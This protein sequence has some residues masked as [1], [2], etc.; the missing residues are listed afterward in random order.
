MG[1]GDDAD[2]AF[3]CAGEDVGEF[4]LR[5]GV[6]MDLRLFEVH[7]SACVG[8]PQCDEDGKNLRYPEADVGDVVHSARKVLQGHMEHNGSVA[9]SSCNQVSRQAGMLQVLY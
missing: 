2:T 4:G 6:K 8:C 3:G 5:A 9:N 7:E 1:L